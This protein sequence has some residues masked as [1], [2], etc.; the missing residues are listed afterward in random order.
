MQ[1]YSKALYWGSQRIFYSNYQPFLK[2]AFFAQYIYS[3]IGVYCKTKKK[4]WLVVYV[5]FVIKQKDYFIKIVTGNVI[6]PC[7]KAERKTMGVLKSQ[8]GIQ[9]DI[10]KRNGLSSLPIA[11]W[12][13]N[14]W[15][16]ED[17]QLSVLR[18]NCW[19]GRGGKQSV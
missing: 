17:S 16:V 3:T 8:Y 6:L 15:L 7:V 10:R 11:C 4:F 5:I 18:M 12:T 13:R 2:H 19:G 9:N 14:D 1:G